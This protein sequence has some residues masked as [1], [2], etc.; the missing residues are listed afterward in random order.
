MHGGKGCH[1]QSRREND[2]IAELLNLVD[3]VRHEPR[4][5][6]CDEPLYLHNEPCEREFSNDAMV[7]REREAGL[8]R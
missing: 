7:S 4:C 6:V 3:R 2:V 5:Q 8:S 1:R